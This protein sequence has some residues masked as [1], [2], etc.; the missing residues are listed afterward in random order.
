MASRWVTAAAAAA[1]AA[2]KSRPPHICITFP[3]AIA[4]QQRPPRPDR[5]TPHQRLWCRMLH[6]CAVSTGGGAGVHR[7][8]TD[9]GGRAVQDRGAAGDA[10]TIL[11]WFSYHFSLLCFTIRPHCSF[12]SPSLSRLCTFSSDIVALKIAACWQAPSVSLINP[13]E[14][15]A[16]ALLEQPRRAG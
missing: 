9:F 6:A 14:L 11:S 13:T 5:S 12:T 7:V 1:A 2:A 3:P 10:P 15:L 4:Q 8:P 16:A